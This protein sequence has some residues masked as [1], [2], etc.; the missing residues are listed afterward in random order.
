MP[1]DADF[2]A[3]LVETCS[4]YSSAATVDPNTY[5][6][7]S[8]QTLL[9][10]NI[11]CRV[12]MSGQAASVQ[13]S[14]GAQSGTERKLIL[15]VEAEYNG[16]RPGYVVVHQGQSYVISQK[17]EVYGEET[18]PHHVVYILDKEHSENGT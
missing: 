13:N 5:Q 12:H 11:P 17:K 1:A 10:S 2:V 14:S 15:M 18:S 8:N 16:A 6:P 9:Y 4:I 3:G 7:I